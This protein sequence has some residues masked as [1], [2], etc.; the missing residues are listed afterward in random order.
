[1][2]V[3]EALHVKYHVTDTTT[4]QVRTVCFDKHVAEQVA[5]MFGPTFVVITVEW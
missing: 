4:G 3:G 1:M 2:T 5:K